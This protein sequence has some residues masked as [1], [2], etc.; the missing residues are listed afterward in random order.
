MNRHTPHR[1][2]SSARGVVMG[3]DLDFM[4]ENP[5][6]V[7]PT[8]YKYVFGALAHVLCPSCCFFFFF[9]D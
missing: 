2:Y 5:I 9:G 7:V 3:L 1:T 6:T 8:C 4:L